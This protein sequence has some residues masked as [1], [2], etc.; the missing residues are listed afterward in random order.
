[1]ALPDYFVRR[2]WGLSGLMK[3]AGR[4]KIGQFSLQ[5]RSLNESSISDAVATF[6]RTETSERLVVNGREVVRAEMELAC[7]GRQLQAAHYRVERSAGVFRH[8]WRYKYDDDGALAKASVSA[9]FRE[10]DEWRYSYDRDGNL[11]S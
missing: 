1:M 10:G 4:P 8:S 11:L 6:S 3:G 5:L 2:R 7:G 9:S